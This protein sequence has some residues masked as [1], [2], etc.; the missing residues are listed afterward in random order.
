[1]KRL[2]ATSQELFIKASCGTIT[3][4]DHHERLVWFFDDVAKQLANI[5]ETSINREDV[6]IRLSELSGK[7][8]IAIKTLILLYD[9]K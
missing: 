4:R 2:D 5:R 7:S 1:M 8:G 6:R 3:E 9:W